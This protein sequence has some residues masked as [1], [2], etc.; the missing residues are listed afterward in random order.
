MISLGA[1]DEVSRPSRGFFESKCRLATETRLVGQLS[2][3]ICISPDRHDYRQRMAVFLLSYL[4][5][6]L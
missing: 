4:A 5:R 3:A 1:L 2:V 6:K